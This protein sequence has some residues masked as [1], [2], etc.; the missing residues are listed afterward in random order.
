MKGR[1]SAVH[2][3]DLNEYLEKLGILRRLERGEMNCFECKDT[4]SL[5][6][7]SAIFPDSGSIKG[8]CNKPDCLSA[9]M[10]WREEK[11]HG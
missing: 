3:D 1:V 4:L 2:E 7:I 10:R 9:L 8:V 5:E 11:R 6:S